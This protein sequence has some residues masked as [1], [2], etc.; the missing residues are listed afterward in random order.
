VAEITRALSRVKV[1]KEAQSR[2]AERLQEEVFAWRRRPL[3]RA[4]PYLFLDATYLKVNCGQRVR[5]AALLVAVGV[6]EEG[7]REL[8]AVEVAG[9]ERREAPCLLLRGLVDMGLEGV[10]ADG[11]RRPRGHPVAVASELPADGSAA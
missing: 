6:D 1:S 9:G 11:E 5:E 8:L 10:P 7:Y 3:E 4:Y 2:I